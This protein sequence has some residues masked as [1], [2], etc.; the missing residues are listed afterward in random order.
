MLSV[1]PFCCSIHIPSHPKVLPLQ[2]APAGRE[3]LDVAYLFTANGLCVSQGIICCCCRIAPDLGFLTHFHWSTPGS[4]SLKNKQ[5]PGCCGDPAWARAGGH[6]PCP[7]S[8]L[9]GVS[10]EAPC[11][12]D[13]PLPAGKGTWARGKLIPCLD[14]GGKGAQTMGR[15]LLHFCFALQIKKVLSLCPQHPLQDRTSG[16]HHPSITGPR[17]SGTAPM[18]RGCLH[19]C[20]GGFGD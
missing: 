9:R 17:K 8:A 16:L 6:S 3:P 19:I 4:D 18:C 13:L 12:P 2:A 5:V 15:D 7:I 10:P 20:T 1:A 14:T 11:I